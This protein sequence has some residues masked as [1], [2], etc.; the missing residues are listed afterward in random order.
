M[1]IW[2]PQRVAEVRRRSSVVELCCDR[3]PPLGGRRLERRN[4]ARGRHHPKIYGPVG[5]PR[6][7]HHGLSLWT[8]GN[9]R[10]RQRNLASSRLG[11]GGDEGR[12][13]FYPDQERRLTPIRATRLACAPANSP[14]DVAASP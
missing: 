3:Q 7:Q 4:R 14:R 5:S 13:L 9:D 6:Q 2:L 12:G 8:P 10:A 1:G 11:E